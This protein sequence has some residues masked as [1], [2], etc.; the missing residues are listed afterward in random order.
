MLATMCL[1]NRRISI[2]VLAVAACL[3]AACGDKDDKSEPVFTLDG[4]IEDVASDTASWDFNADAVTGD[5]SSWTSGDSGPIGKDTSS[6]DVPSVDCGPRVVTSCQGRCGLKLQSNP[7]HCDHGCID[8]GDCCSGFE[9]VCGCTTKLDCEDGNDCTTDLCEAHNKGKKYC[10][11]IPFFGCCATDFDCDSSSANKCVTPKCIAGSCSDVP[12]NCDDGITCTVDSC[13]V[14]T[15]ACSNQLPANKCLIDGMCHGAGAAKPGSGGCQLCQPDKDASLWTSK[16]GSC[17]IEGVCVAAGAKASSATDE[18][19]VCNPDKN[20]DAWSVTTGNCWIDGQC[21][22][23][24]VVNPAQ[25][26]CSVCTPSIHQ[27]SWSGAAGK[28]FIAGQCL[29]QGQSPPGASCVTC[30]PAS[31]TSALTISAKTCWISGQCYNEGQSD[32]NACNVCDANKANNAWTVL[33]MG[34]A[35]SD[36]SPCTLDTIC[37]ASGQCKGK[38][39]PNCCE[40]NLDC[41]GKVSLQTCEKALCQADGTCI[42]SKDPLCCTSGKCC[43]LQASTFKP[44]GTPCSTLK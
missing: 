8:R 2:Y 31:S 13:S 35:C 11:Q 10:K 37:T 23:A 7:C 44:K 17:F 36:D 30:Q 18:C 22:A 32:A 5:A 34:A 20:G 33:P 28:C 1:R 19:R 24:G 3:V 25:P 43:D 21:Y 29:S 27:D 39:K 15:G 38:T 41:A 6:V 4:V 9:V 40:S 16:V 26:D 12:K 14:A 42:A